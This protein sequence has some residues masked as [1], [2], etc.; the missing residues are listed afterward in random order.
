MTASSGRD[1][2]ARRRAN[3]PRVRLLVVAALAVAVT[4][5]ADIG[6]QDPFLA[7]A[8]TTVGGASAAQAPELVVVSE[9]PYSN[10]GTYH[11]T[12]V[13][14]HSESFGSMIVSAFQAGRSHRCGASNLGWSRSSDAG[15]TWTDGFLPDTTIHATPPGSWKRA[16][17]PVVAYDA[18]H[19]A[20]LVIPVFAAAAEGECVLGDVT[21]CNVWTASATI[22]L[23]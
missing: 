12:E 7:M 10:P 11:R 16:T 8:D 14:P 21:S 20:W 13:E 15:S 17:D 19:D 1:G 3:I 5:S 2:T 9:D 23:S 18:K 6:I 4:L 22:P